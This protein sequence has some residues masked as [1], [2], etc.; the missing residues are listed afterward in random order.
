LGD[1]TSTYRKKKGKGDPLKL[2]ENRG[3]GTPLKKKSDRGF[4][5]SKEENV[6]GTHRETKAGVSPR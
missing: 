5:I 2:S 1:Q 3:Q 4:D 6:L